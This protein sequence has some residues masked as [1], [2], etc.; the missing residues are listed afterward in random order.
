MLAGILLGFSGFSGISFLYSDGGT[1]N[2]SGGMPTFIE[3]KFLYTS[4]KQGWIEEVTPEFESWFSERFDIDINVELIVTGTHD[5]VNRIL[6]GSESD[7]N[8]MRA[9]ASR[10]KLTECSEWGHWQRKL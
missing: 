8:R 2:G 9:L 7:W 10:D 3:L 6:D 5:T 4:E 1:Q